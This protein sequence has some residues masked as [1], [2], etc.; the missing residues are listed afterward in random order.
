MANQEHLDILRQGV[1]AWNQWRKEHNDIIPDLS[2][3]NLSGADL[4]TTNL[5]QV[6]LTSADLSFANLSF[7]DLS[8]ANLIGANLIE[9]I[10]EGADLEGASLIKANLSR[11]YLT[12]ANLMA[13]NFDEADLEGANLE[14]A[15][16]DSTNLTA[17]NLTS[18]NLER[19]MVGWTTFGNVDL[20]MVKGLETVNHVGP[21]TIG[22]DTISRSRGH[23]P[24]IF[25]K[26]AGVDDTFIAHIQSL[27]GKP[28]DYYTCFISYSSK[29]HE[30]VERLY[31][32]LKNKGVRCWFAP[33]DMSIGDKI[34]DRIDES[35]RRYDKLLLVLS[36][37]SMM[38]EWVEDELEAALEK[39]RLARERG[40]EQTVLF[41]VRLDDVVKTTTK[42]WA[43]K[44]RRQRHIGDFR[45]WKNHDEYQKAL[46][47]LLRD[48]KARE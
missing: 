9:A 30:F 47:R 45:N 11:A 41:P 2:K 6:N 1:E 37:Y 29:D 14:G 18:T 42:A 19:S 15:N 23:I 32:D 26:G 39:E 40:E 12:E 21:S 28:I 34:R 46:S 10:L 35:I 27:V 5:S 4:E 31:A 13:A 36:E 17:A 33:H 25:L 22:T 43:A 8:V 44:L 3:A 24:E 7:A 48:L 38:S 16:L 20:H